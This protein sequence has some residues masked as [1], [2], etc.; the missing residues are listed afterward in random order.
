MKNNAEQT[1]LTP[2]KIRVKKIK[3]HQLTLTDFYWLNL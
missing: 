2:P 1:K 3:I